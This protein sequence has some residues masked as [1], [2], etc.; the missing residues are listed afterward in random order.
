MKKVVS[1]ILVLVMVFAMAVP[2][3]AAQSVVIE[4]YVSPQYG[5][6]ANDFLYKIDAEKIIDKYSTNT[7]MYGHIDTY[8]CNGPVTLTVEY[9]VVNNGGMGFSASYAT[10]IAVFQY[11]S[12]NFSPVNDSERAGNDYKFNLNKPGVYLFS[13]MVGAAPFKANLLIVIKESK[14]PAVK[15]ELKSFSDVP[16]KRWSHDAIM[17]I[18]AQG[19]FNGVTNPDK[20]GIAKFN[21]EGTMK[22]SEFITVIE[23][24]LW[25]EE[26]A[27]YIESHDQCAY[28]YSRNYDFAVDHGL[29]TKEEFSINEM[30]RDITR[31]EMALIA[32]RDV[33]GLGEFIGSTEGVSEMI[34]DYNKVDYRY[35]GSVE[36]AYMLGIITGMDNIGTFAPKENLTRE[37]GAM[38]VYRILNESARVLPE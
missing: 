10:D 8:E 11:G 24:V 13:G 17:G 3:F 16:A 29:I 21:P 20:N 32:I 5:F 35:T 30:N 2:A 28:W 34:A 14:A 23:R 25:Q 33:S 26:L 9:D 12:Y 4:D 27:E 38:V 36:A 7:I 6:A 37:Q 18:V 22:L 19:L 31:E 15:Y 1:L